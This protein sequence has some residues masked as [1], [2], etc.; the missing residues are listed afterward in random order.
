V[1]A[2]ISS[3]GCTSASAVC[4]DRPL[5]AGRRIQAEGGSTRTRPRTWSLYVPNGKTTSTSPRRLV[6]QFSVALREVGADAHAGDHGLLRDVEGDEMMMVDSV[7][8]SILSWW[9]SFHFSIEGAPGR[10]PAPSWERLRGWRAS[11]SP[12]RSFRDG[13]RCLVIRH[14][15]ATPLSCPPRVETAGCR[16]GRCAPE[17]G[18]RQP[19]SREAANRTVPRLPG[20]SA[21]VPVPRSVPGTRLPVARTQDPVARTR[22]RTRDPVA[23]CPLP[24]PGRPDPEPGSRTRLPGTRLPGL[25]VRRL[26]GAS[27]ASSPVRRAPEARVRRAERRRREPGKGRPRRGEAAAGERPGSQF[28]TGRRSTPS[29]AATAHQHRPRFRG[30][31]A[32]EAPRGAARS[33]AVELGVELCFE[34]EVRDVEALR[35]RP[36]SWSGPT[37]SHSAVRDRY[38]EHFRPRLDE[39][40][41]RFVWLG[42]TLPFDAFTFYFKENEHG[43]WRV[44]AYRYEPERSRPSSS[45]APTRPSPRR[46]STKADEDATVAYSRSSSPR[47]RRPSLLKNR[48]HLAQL[49]HGAERRWHHENVVLIGDAVHTAHF[50]VGSGTKLAMEDAI[51]LADHLER[52]PD[53]GRALPP[54]RRSGAGSREPA[55]RRPGR[56]SSGSR[57]P[58]ATTRPCRRSPSTSAC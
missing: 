35:P 50:S 10:P 15:A 13:I 42:T 12:T 33:R 53:L 16:R 18:A 20:L 37:A 36:T 25:R 27:E 7:G 3:D 32:P 57:T 22:T 39:R 28:G 58:S 2:A 52:E 9:V 6:L 48:S 46:G 30:D 40:P 24:G 5:E 55:A 47:T 8:W 34:T 29:S 17:G 1:I 43:L 49:P 31:V 51:A 4:R 38:A 23:R 45:S 14:I 19:R 56:A 26:E 41:N 44:H 21:S 54:T 11:P